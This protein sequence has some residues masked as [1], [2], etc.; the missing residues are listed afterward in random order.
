V[1]VAGVLL[2]ASIP[3]RAQTVETNGALFYE[4]TYSDRNE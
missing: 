3:V 4:T 2:A 1:A